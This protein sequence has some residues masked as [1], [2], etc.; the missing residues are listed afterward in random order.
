MESRRARHAAQSHTKRWFTRT[1][2]VRVIAI[3]V[4]LVVM[5]AIVTLS[6]VFTY[7]HTAGPASSIRPPTQT[8]TTPPSSAT[9]SPSPNDPSSLTTEFTQ[10]ENNLHAKMGVAVSAV[11]NGQEPTT[12][13][14]WQEGPAWSTIKVPLVIAAYRQQKPQQVTD[15]MKAAITESDNSAAESLWEQLGDPTTAAQKVQQI[16]QE[17]GD[18]TTTVESRKLRPEFTAFG[19]TIWSL[20]NQV[21]FTASA[22]CNSENGPIFDLMSQVK[23][24]QSWGIGDI[25][26]TQFKGGWGPSPSSKYLVRQIGVLTTPAGKVAVAIAAEPA[27]GSFDDGTRDLNEVAKWLTG[28]LGALP[29][30]QCSR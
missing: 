2:F 29:A 20:V 28:H 26:G 27:S 3:L 6:A 25:P 11:G 1:R 23:P 15:V 4:A 8:P 19:Q 9:M 13:G 30:G 10:L 7:R 21:R 24:D 18:T 16:L 12:W 17:T 14:E 5:A 22:F